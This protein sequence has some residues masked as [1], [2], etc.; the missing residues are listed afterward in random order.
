M[1]TQVFS[2][3]ELKSEDLDE[4]E[5]IPIQIEHEINRV[6]M[7]PHTVTAQ[8]STDTDVNQSSFSVVEQNIDEMNSSQVSFAISPIFSQYACSK[9]ANLNFHGR[10]FSLPLLYDIPEQK[11]WGIFFFIFFA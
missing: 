2:E 7:S 8:E 9:L 3:V 4:P 5:I 6:K 1:S 11:M 10:Y